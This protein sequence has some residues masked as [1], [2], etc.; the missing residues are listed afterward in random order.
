MMLIPPERRQEEH[1]ILDGL[2]A[3]RRIEHHETVRIT[4]DGRKQLATQRQ[5]WQVVDGTLRGIWMLASRT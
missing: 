2:R 4:K 3:G 1:H 5:Q